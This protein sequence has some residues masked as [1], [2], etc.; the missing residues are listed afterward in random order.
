MIDPGTASIVAA[1]LSSLLGGLFG[2]RNQQKL[3]PEQLAL[4][5][6]QTRATDTQTAGQTTENA[7]TK[8]KLARKQSVD[9]LFRAVSM[10]AA[11]R[12][13][14]YAQQG[15]DFSKLYDPI[16]VNESSL[17]PTVGNRNRPSGVPSTGTALP[18][19][20]SY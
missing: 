17:L 11:S 19:P 3:T 15:F 4:I 1:G 8:L 5:R 20:P 16:S 6:S 2:K 18:R 13:P 7:L 12:L 14:I 9:P 10:M